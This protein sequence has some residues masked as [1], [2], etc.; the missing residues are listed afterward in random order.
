[1]GYIAQLNIA[2][3]LTMQMKPKAANFIFKKL[4]S[5]SFIDKN[6]LYSL[7]A[8]NYIQMKNEDEAKKAYDQINLTS[9]FY[10]EWQTFLNSENRSTIH[11]S[12]LLY[13]YGHY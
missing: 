3:S 4:F 11:T 12:Y 7:L 6:M 5:V 9:Q 10:K 8:V 1:M 13:G 2:I